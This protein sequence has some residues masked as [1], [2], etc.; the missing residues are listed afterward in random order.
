MKNII[1]IM[2]LLFASTAQAEE[3]D[4]KYF[5]SWLTLSAILQSKGIIPAAPN[6]NAII[7]MC[8]PL[9]K[10]DDETDYNRCLYEKAMDEMQ[11]PIDYKYCKSQAEI[12]YVKDYTEY[13]ELKNQQPQKVTIINKNGTTR[14]IEYA[15]P[16]I[17]QN[18]NAARNRD[19]YFNDCM[20]QEK[21]WNSSDKWL[22]GRHKPPERPTA[23]EPAK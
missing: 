7:P 5:K 2:L 10:S 18:F 13:M 12:Q 20:I 23:S 21:N 15:P 19:F 22:M 16:Q 11:W 3:I 14:V 6:W 17:S 4:P 9:K 1:V 8:L